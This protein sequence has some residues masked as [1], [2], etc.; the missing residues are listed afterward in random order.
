MRLGTL[1]RTGVGLLTAACLIALAAP[2]TRTE[3]QG[4]APDDRPNII[5]ITT[6]DQTTYDMQWMPYV[7]Q[8]VGGHGV[9]F[10]DGQSPHSLCCPARAEILTGQYGQNNGV[11]H[12]AGVNGGYHALLNRNNTVGRWLHDSGYQTALAGKFLNGYTE[13]YGEPEGWDHWNPYVGGT[14]FMT[15]RYYND[16]KPLVRRGYVDDITNAYARSYIDEFAGPEPF[17]VWISNYAPHRAKKRTD[18][19]ELSYA[20]PRFQGTL[21]NVTLPVLRKASFNERHVADQPKEARGPKVS[22]FD[23]QQRFTSRIEALQAAD[24]NVQMLVEQLEA[25]GELDNTYIFFVSD[26]GYLL[27][28]HRLSHK[29]YIFSE[30]MAIPFS[31]RVPTADGGTISDLPVTL[32]DLAPTFAELGQATP[33]RLV[34]GVSF[35]PLLRGEEQP[36]RDTQLIQTGRDLS[37]YDSWR[38][39]GARTDRYT[40]GRDVTNGFEQLYDR[41]R[42]PYEIH[43]RAR[44]P[45]YQPVLRAMRKRMAALRDCAGAACSRSFGAV[46]DPL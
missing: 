7:Q 43:N 11:H 4:T 29:N 23:M 10:T 8:L 1:V 40:Y 14:D 9:E 2:Q 41:L 38:I 24:E 44:D 12:N 21:S 15:T 26:N 36:W 39:R 13:K 3:A 30:S 32:A 19:S 33:E 20:A 45:R 37:T 34:D 18:R 31:V 28:E 17:F 42:D 25:L 16:G 5:L 6:D 22:A 35:A 46:P 27:G